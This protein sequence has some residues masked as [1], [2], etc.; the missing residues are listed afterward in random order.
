MTTHYL[1]YTIVRGRDDG[2]YRVTPPDGLQWADPAINLETAQR[3][4]RQHR[5]EVRAHKSRR[6]T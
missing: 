3:W 6:T 5:A 1:G 2:Y 4:V